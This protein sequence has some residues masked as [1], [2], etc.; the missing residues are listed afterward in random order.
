ML[1]HSP[2]AE[3]LRPRTLAE[4]IGQQHLLGEGMALRV[5]FESGQPHSCILWGPPG[6]GKTTIARLMADAFDAQFLSISAVL[7]GVKEIR[8]AVEQAMAARDSLCAKLSNHRKNLHVTML[9]LFV[10]WGV[11]EQKFAPDFKVPDWPKPLKGNVCTPRIV[12]PETLFE[13]RQATGLRYGAAAMVELFVSTGMRRSEV[14]GLT[15]NQLLFDRIPIDQTT[16]KP[17]IYAGGTIILDKNNQVIK[18]RKS[19]V[20]F[21]SKIAARMLRAYMQDQGMQEGL[22][23][24]LFPFDLKQL[25]KWMAEIQE[26]FPELQDKEVMRHVGKVQT[27]EG[28]DIDEVEDERLKKLIANQVK[29]N[30]NFVGPVDPQK[31]QEVPEKMKGI[32][33][34]Q[35][36]HT[37]ACY[38]LFRN[39]YGERD[40][41]RRVMTMLGH[42]DDE[43]TMIYLSNLAAIKD[44]A[45]WARIYL[46]RPTDWSRCLPRGVH[47]RERRKKE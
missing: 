10:E 44:D 1:S 28:Y 2:L 6:V 42:S 43:T 7:G 5:A 35:F 46:G 4:V 13:V 14:F 12:P 29:R 11:K 19:R 25:Y 31:Q 3:Q 22:N 8:E 37:F 27:V 15:A 18:G 33:P 39:Y 17:S 9:K 32:H 24:P 45:Q 47:R 40:N 16:N 23:I 21:F 30:N 41:I 36:R 26:M 20:V 34:H 38:Q